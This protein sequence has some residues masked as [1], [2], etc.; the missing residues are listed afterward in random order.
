MSN[1]PIPNL[2]IAIFD[3]Q[4]SPTVFIT[5]YILVNYKVFRKRLWHANQ[6]GRCGIWKKSDVNCG[7]LL[8]IF[9]YKAFECI[10]DFVANSD[11]I[12]VDAEIST[13]VDLFEVEAKGTIIA[14][15]DGNVLTFKHMRIALA[16]GRGASFYECVVVILVMAKHALIALVNHHDA[17]VAKNCL[18]VNAKVCV[19]F[20]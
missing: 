18:D 8:S 17:V 19:D 11:S 5:T 16:C 10:A 1:L 14:A 13:N 15:S 7:Y 6:T 4:L 20:S 9:L 2:P 3:I 12:A